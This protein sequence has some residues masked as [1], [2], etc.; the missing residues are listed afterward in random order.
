MDMFL[1]P[2]EKKKEKKLPYNSEVKYVVLESFIYLGERSSIYFSF[3][4]CTLNETG[5]HYCGYLVMF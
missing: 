5:K 3:S 4:C 1:E 2:K